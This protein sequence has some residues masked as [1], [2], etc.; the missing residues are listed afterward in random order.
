ARVVDVYGLKERSDKITLDAAGDVYVAGGGQ[1][2][3]AGVTCAGRFVI[4]KYHS[5]GDTVWVSDF[6][7]PRQYLTFE[8]IKTLTYAS[9]RVY[10]CGKSETPIDRGFYTTRLNTV[11]GTVDWTQDFGLGPTEGA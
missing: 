11:D 7:R 10:M 6:P 4:I 2:M 9:G 3:C 5:N 1:F 8:E